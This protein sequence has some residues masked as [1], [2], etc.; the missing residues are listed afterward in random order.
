MMRDGGGWWTDIIT[1]HLADAFIHSDLVMGAYILHTG[2]PGI[3]P[4]YPSWKV[5]FT[6]WATVD[7]L[8]VLKDCV[9]WAQKSSW[10]LCACH[11][12][13]FAA[14]QKDA[15]LVQCMDIW[16]THLWAYLRG[17][18]GAAMLD[19]RLDRHST[20]SVL[21]KEPSLLQCG[22]HGCFVYFYIY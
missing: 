7:H 15:V 17:F 9:F 21:T 3:Q 22:Q 8:S 12:F 20:K 19:G 1:C 16:C 6:N 13:F 18:C 5:P 2:G 14:F 10:I 4:H 11:F